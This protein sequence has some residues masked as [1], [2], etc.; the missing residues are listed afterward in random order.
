MG[1]SAIRAG[2]IGLADM[3][4]LTVTTRDGLRLRGEIEG[5]RTAPLVVLAHGGGQTRHAWTGAAE[6]LLD[7]DFSVVRMDARGHGDSDW[8]PD[9]DY[10][11]ETF[12]DDLMQLLDTLGRP[13]ALVGASLGGVSALLT[14]AQAPDRVWSLILVD[15]VPR[16]AGPGVE[17]VRRFMHAHSDG[18]ATLEEASAAV[19]AY[20]PHRPPPKDPGNLMRNLRE[21]N[22]RLH[23]HWDPAVT[24]AAPDAALGAMLSARLAAIPP[25]LPLLLVSGAD[26]DVVDPEAVAE[27]SRQAPQAETVIV[28]RA[29]HMVAAD[30]NDAFGEAISTFLKRAAP[31]S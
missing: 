25:S 27:F 4:A 23:W 3:T 31:P 26:S 16:F 17:R 24:G 14:A 11:M 6:R 18:F 29:G 21:R 30:R 15:I 2:E 7:E 5:E 9:R 8:S 13:A 10:R 28:P 19:R 1:R 22:G 20:N 12:A